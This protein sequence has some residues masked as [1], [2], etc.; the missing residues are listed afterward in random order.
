MAIVSTTPFSGQLPGTSGLRKKVSIFAQSGYAENYIQ[1]VFDCIPKNGNPV[2]VLG[3]DGRYLTDVVVNT[4]LRMAAANGFELTVVGQNGWLST[5]AASH[6]VCKCNA[7]CGILLTASHNPGGRDGDFGIKLIVAN[8]GPAPVALTTAIHAK[9]KSITSYD[10]VDETNLDLNTLGTFQLGNMTVKVIDPVSSY[11]TLMQS[12]F[13]FD[14][15]MDLAKSGFSLKFDGL[16]GI[17]GPYAKKIFVDLL[18]FPASSLVGCTPLPDFGGQNPDPNPIYANR[19]YNEMMRG[20]ADFG[21]ASDSDADRHM[22]MGRGVF[23][24]PSDSL[25]ILASHMSKAPGYCN[26][27]VGVARSLGTS[28]AVDRVARHLNI[29]CFETPT[30]WKH[31]NSLL[32]RGFVNLCGEESYG[33]SSN[34]A[35]E[36]DGIWAILLWL[37]ILAVTRSSVRQLMSEHWQSFGRTYY[38]RR[39]YEELDE[40]ACLDLMK[41]LRHRLAT[42]EGRATKLGE[43]TLAD[44]FAYHNVMDGTIA[45]RQGMRLCF[46]LG[47]RV[48]LRLSGTGTVGATL[49]IYGER[50]DASRFDRSTSEFLEPLFDILDQIAGISAITRKFEPT[51]V[52]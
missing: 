38:E 28:S 39:D 7:R 16:S 14:A 46:A 26:G 40:T 45:T 31:F 35:R 12:L 22:I 9:T 2:L 33:A 43:I 32:D 34:H 3:G 37:N 19:F 21:A 18:G 42:L 27:A 8:G 5:P 6:L 41:R 47:A 51:L 29:P 4:V 15:I 36:K 44:E 25:A 30:G 17:S 24:T 20:A 23:V 13:D 50:Y 10:I 11:V 49:R 1:S 52:T 48:I